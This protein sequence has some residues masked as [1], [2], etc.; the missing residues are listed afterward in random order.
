[1]LTPLRHGWWM[2]SDGKTVFAQFT[3]VWTSGKK[4]CNKK[5]LI[6]QKAIYTEFFHCTFAKK[7][8]AYLRN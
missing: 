2:A 1:L 3:K 8:Y 6:P 7:M 4:D 5:M